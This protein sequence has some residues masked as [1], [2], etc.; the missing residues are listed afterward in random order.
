MFNRRHAFTLVE[1]LVVIA[2]IAL[3]ISILLPT[4]AAAREA[5]KRSV[6]ASNVRQN[7]VGVNA[8]AADYEGRLPPHY[9]RPSQPVVTYQLKNGGTYGGLGLLYRLTYVTSGEIFYCPSMLAPEFSYLTPSNPSGVG[10]T[11]PFL[12]ANTTY[13]SSYYYLPQVVRNADGSIK[14]E[15]QGYMRLEEMEP[16]R[17]LV[18]D[19][20]HGDE[21]FQAHKQD[22]VEGWTVGAQDGS[23]VFRSDSKIWSAIV[24]PGNTV[25]NG[26]QTSWTRFLPCLDRLQGTDTIYTKPPAAPVLGS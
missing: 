20:L 10:A 15:S 16:G 22:G 4:L 19:I 25:M 9:G 11:Q 14:S 2:I 26:V 17:T 8:Y 13:R 12:S 7:I 18:M 5:S 23:T 21:K 3:L 6:C 24:D 1:L